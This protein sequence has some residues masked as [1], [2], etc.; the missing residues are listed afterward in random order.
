VLLPS[1]T[2]APPSASETTRLPSATNNRIAAAVAQV[3]MMW[4]LAIRTVLLRTLVSALFS[5]W[6]GP[7]FRREK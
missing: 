4:L 6:F 5:Q 3:V 2:E 7:A 1:G